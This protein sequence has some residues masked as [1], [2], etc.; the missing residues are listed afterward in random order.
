ML[1]RFCSASVISSGK[2]VSDI[3][4]NFIIIDLMAEPQNE[5]W[6]TNSS[7]KNSSKHRTVLLSRETQLLSC[8]SKILTEEPKLDINL[9]IINN[10][11]YYA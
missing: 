8:V 3:G 10:P 9:I 4:K 6:M 11:Y 7:D 5:G 1:K 2:C